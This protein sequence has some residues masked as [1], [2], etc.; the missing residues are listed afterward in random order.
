MYSP[1]INEYLRALNF[2]V[3]YSEIEYIMNCS[4]Q[5]FRLKFEGIEDAYSRYKMYTNDGHTWDVFVKNKYQEG[6]EGNDGRNNYWN[7]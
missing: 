1:E 7:N 5:V 3:E 4:P 2:T 6:N